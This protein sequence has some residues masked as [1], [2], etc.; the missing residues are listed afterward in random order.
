M[1]AI[2]RSRFS[3][4]GGKLAFT[5]I[6]VLVAQILIIPRSANATPTVSWNT[7]DNS[8]FSG[9]GEVN[10][11]TPPDLKSLKVHSTSISELFVSGIVTIQVPPLDY[12]LCLTVDG[13]SDAWSWPDGITVDVNGGSSNWGNCWYPSYSGSS[14]QISIDTSSWPNGIHSLD[15]ATYDVYLNE[16]SIFDGSLIVANSP[17]QTVAIA[18]NSNVTVQWD[19]PGGSFGF[20]S[21]VYTATATSQ[22]G[23]TFSCTTTDTPSSCVIRGLTN[24]VP[25]QVEVH[26]ADPKGIA[27]PS[28]T[29]AI[30]LTVNPHTTAQGLSNTISGAATSLAWTSDPPND[31]ATIQKS[32]DGTNWTTL[33]TSATQKFTITGAG[34][35]YYV[36]VLSSSGASSNVIGI[37]TGGLAQQTV[38]FV[39]S[40]G[41]PVSGGSVSWAMA[42]G[43][44]RSSIVYGLLSDGTYTF[45]AAPGGIVNLTLTNA[46][47]P[48][49]AFVSGTFQGVLSSGTVLVITLPAAPS[50]AINSV[51]VVTPSGVPVWGAKVSIT[52]LSS[53][54]TVGDATFVIPS[55]YSPCASS[56]YTY[57][58]SLSNLQADIN[59]TV[60]F[61]GYYGGSSDV[62]N[63]GETEISVVYDDGVVTQTPPS[64]VPTSSNTVVT[65]EYEPYVASI[66]TTV[67]AP[68]A[69]VLTGVTITLNAGAAPAFAGIR[70]HVAGSLANLRVTAVL[71]AGY[72]ACAGQIVTAVTNARGQ[73]A[74]K[75]CSTQTGQIKFKTPGVLIPGAVSFFIAGTASQPVRTLHG[76]TPARGSASLTWVA[77]SFSGGVPVLSYQI[78]ISA[79][80]KKTVTASTTKLKLSVAGLVN[81]TR[82]TVTVRAVTRLG[83]GAPAAAVIAVA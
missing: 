6:L 17:S 53:S 10:A 21:V 7:A 16:T 18:G 4:T 36:R 60:T 46:V 30:P 72:R 69:N 67:V 78:T 9:D 34:L 22:D 65:L 43:G 55:Q 64:V 61:W 33:G 39:T 52:N 58:C 59:G 37:T 44:S 2:S 56:D 35:S 66:S 14:G 40:T 29:M 81:A 23:S 31:N 47:M 70:P 1:N 5:V 32:S 82:Y 76:T 26:A 11:S 42:N 13:V 49:G 15:V 63:D 51:Q 25:Y 75:I 48:D 50:S 77:P 73:A 27:P 80:G 79:P 54:V 19:P 8:V 71:P 12:Q 45:P 83:I 62:W 74:F 68:S 20:P 3:A 38:Q 41:Q 57:G 28:P 24:G